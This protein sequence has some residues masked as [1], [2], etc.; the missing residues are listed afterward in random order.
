MNGFCSTGIWPLIRN[1]HGPDDFL[2]SYVRDGPEPTQDISSPSSNSFPL[3]STSGI[4]HDYSLPSS[5]GSLVVINHIL[6]LSTS[7]T[8][9]SPSKYQSCAPAISPQLLDIIRP[10]PKAP[11]RKNAVGLS[12]RSKEEKPDIDW[13]TWKNKLIEDLLKRKNL[14]KVKVKCDWKKK[15]VLNLLQRMDLT[16]VKVKSNCKKNV[17]KQIDI[18]LSENEDSPSYNDSEDSLFS[19]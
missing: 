1:I 2:S 13:H 4:D 19:R 16:K 5:S 7:A 18:T 3:L 6:Y 10:F 8:F 14:N 9:T 15:L 11:P 17:S 12:K